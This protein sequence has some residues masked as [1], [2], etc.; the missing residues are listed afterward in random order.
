MSEEKRVTYPGKDVDVSW[1]GRLCIHVGECGRAKGELFVGGRQPW[2]Q[3]DL[4]SADEVIEVVERCPTGALTHSHKTGTGEAETPA[5]ENSVRVMYNGPYY[6]R[7]DLQIE[8]AAPD[9]KG[10]RFR[11]ALCRCGASENKPFCDNSHDKIAFKDSGAVG[12]SGDGNDGEAGPLQVK[13]APNGPLLLSGNFTI[14][15]ASGRPAFTGTR[16]ALCRCGQSRNK[17]F[18]DGSHKDAGFEAD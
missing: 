4:V 11:A 17:P 2:C 15:A 13:R 3:P 7:G 1:D 10:T 18:C 14:Y 6:V 12:E 8:G 9:M 16:A 5:E